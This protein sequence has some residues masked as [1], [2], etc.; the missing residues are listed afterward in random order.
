MPTFT[1]SI[2]LFAADKQ[3]FVLLDGELEKNAKLNEQ[4]ITLT[5]RHVEG[6]STYLWEGDVSIQKIAGTIFKAA[7][8][9]KKKYSFSIIKNK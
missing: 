9:T 8:K 2:Q 1:T 3:D 6:E 5:T 7:P 4:R